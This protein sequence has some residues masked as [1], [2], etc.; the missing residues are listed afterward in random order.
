MGVVFADRKFVDK[1]FVK[2]ICFY[3]HSFDDL[4]NVFPGRQS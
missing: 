3:T 2:K 1:G 4:S